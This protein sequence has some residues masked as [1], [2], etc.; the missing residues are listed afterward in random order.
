MKVSK[1][2]DNKYKLVVFDIDGVLNEHGGNIQRQSK[3][4]IDLLRD[5]NVRIGYASGKHA[6]YIQGGLVWS[7]LLQKDTVIVAEN[8]G[9]IYEPNLRKTYLEDKYID[10]VKLL[11]SVFYNLYSKREGFLNFAGQTVWE[12]PKET[13][14]CLYPSEKEDIKK[15]AGLLQ[16]IVDINRLSLYLVE[17]P[18][19]VDVLQKGI[20]K[21]TGLKHICKW[22]G[23]EMKDIV[24]FGDS[25]NDLEMMREAGFSITLENGLRKIK[26]LVRVKG[27][28]G[29]ISAKGCGKGVLEAVCMLVE[30][31]LV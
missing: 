25:L 8:G 12:E 11:R 5:R 27:K 30:N 22:F 29:Y 18:D 16:E 2:K 17:N 7:G 14:F 19:S 26:N 3:K 21:A 6:W 31:N 23:I 4:A 13:L 24:A 28:N 9:V 20:N 15:L 10:D 1:K